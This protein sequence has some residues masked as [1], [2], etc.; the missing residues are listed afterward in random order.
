MKHTTKL[1]IAV[2]A[3]VST[4]LLGAVA[5][6]RP[7]HA[8]PQNT[9]DSMAITVTA[10]Q[11]RLGVEVLQISPELRKRLGAPADRGVLVDGVRANSP[12]AKA[13][14][15]VGD[16]IVRL[17]GDAAGSASD[18]LNAMSDRKKGDTIEVDVVRDRNPVELRATLDN[19]GMVFRGF[20]NGKR[21]EVEPQMRNWFRQMPQLGN[22]QQFGDRALQQQL[23]QAQTRIE[24]LERRLDRLEHR[25][26]RT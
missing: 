5:I 7:D 23:D 4:T 21:F 18:M 17:D 10:Q 13:G 9:P 14:I 16:V 19:D 26:P 6:A 15:E 11:G 2:A 22:M 12:A 8:K 3:A 20:K 1:S 24:Q 25:Q